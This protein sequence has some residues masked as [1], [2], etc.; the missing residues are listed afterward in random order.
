MYELF[1]K[2]LNF[3]GEPLR[4]LLTLMLLVMLIKLFAGL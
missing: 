1:F 4:T 2:I 3:N